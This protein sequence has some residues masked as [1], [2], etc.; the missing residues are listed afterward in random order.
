MARLSRLFQTPPSCNK[1][2]MTGNIRHPLCLCILPCTGKGT[3]PS[4]IK[5]HAS[6]THILCPLNCLRS[7]RRP[8]TQIHSKIRTCRRCQT[9]SLS[10]Y[11]AILLYCLCPTHDRTGWRYIICSGY[12]PR[13]PISLFT[14]ILSSAAGQCVLLSS[15]T[16]SVRGLGFPMFSPIHLGGHPTFKEFTWIADAFDCHR[17]SNSCLCQL[18][19][20]IDLFASADLS[21]MVN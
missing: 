15:K 7:S 3:L 12:R 6:L 11:A 16:R 2:L 21:K 5:L 4:S 1:I 19:A 9:D 18:V 14:F 17:E 10:E 8:K 13:W 20:Y